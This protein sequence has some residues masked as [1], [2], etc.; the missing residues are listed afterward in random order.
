MS[1]DTLF[2][3]SSDALSP[4]DVNGTEDVYEFEPPGVGNCTISSPSFSNRSGGC[5]GLVSSGT[6][7]EESGFMDASQ[8]DGDVFFL[9]TSKLVPQ[10]FDT[11]LDL[12]DAHVCTSAS[13]CIKSPEPPGPPCASEASCKAPPTP[14]PEIFGAP[15]SATFSGAGNITPP[16][17][18]PKQPTK[19]QLLA[20][21]LA[22]C[23][24]KHKG[25]S[26]QAKRRRSSCEAQARKKYGAK[27]K[28]TAAATRKSQR[29]GSGR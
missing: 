4:Q 9:T 26:K 18:T 5:V 17:A 8:S 23:R 10:D 14:Q 27:A 19:A 2:F 20:K 28:K 29:R 3:N 7:R 24:A 6:S 22:S 15:A 16:P 13:P 21:A 25:K 12:Y 1:R 11:A